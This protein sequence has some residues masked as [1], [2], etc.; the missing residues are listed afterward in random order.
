MLQVIR[1][2][3][4]S[5]LPTF[6]VHSSHFF[7]YASSFFKFSFDSE[8][9]L[10]IFWSIVRDHWPCR[11]YE[12]EYMTRHTPPSLLSLVGDQGAQEEL[13]PLQKLQ[14]LPKVAQTIFSTSL[15]KT[16]LRITCVSGIK[17]I[18][19]V[20]VFKNIMCGSL[21]FSSIWLMP[22]CCF[23]SLLTKVM[24]YTVDFEVCLRYLKTCVWDIGFR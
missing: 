5:P 14:V 16:I 2:G 6:G 19:S 1:V 8:I 11:V 13:L 24:V 23:L 15:P 21:A 12:R 10:L 18:W 3:N 17:Q 4:G 7:S 20:P 22:K 9:F